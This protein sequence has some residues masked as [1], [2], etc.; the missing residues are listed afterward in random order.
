[1]GLV[2]RHAVVIA[3]PAIGDAG[4]LQVCLFELGDCFECV[5]GDGV[6]CDVS[7]LSAAL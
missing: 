1:M 6:D 2:I 3:E 7:V 5:F 4:I